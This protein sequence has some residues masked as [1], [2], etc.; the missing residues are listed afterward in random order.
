MG[1]R[2]RFAALLRT[3]RVG[4]QAERRASAAEPRHGFAPKKAGNARELPAPMGMVQSL[5]DAWEDGLWHRGFFGPGAAAGE[6]DAQA[7]RAAS[8]E[9]ERVRA[10]ATMD[11]LRRVIVRSS[12]TEG[13]A[14][15]LRG[16]LEALMKPKQQRPT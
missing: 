1:A 15:L 3:P 9:Q 14:K 2:P 13:E 12:P 7:L 6:P 16:S 5:L 10:K 8:T 11:K 4:E